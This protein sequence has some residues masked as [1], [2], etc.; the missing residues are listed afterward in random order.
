MT[1]SDVR[2]SAAEARAIAQ[3]AYIYGFPMVDNYRILHAYF[4]NR[5]SPEYKGPWNE[6]R[7]VPRVFSPDDKAIQT[8]NSD[9]PYSFVGL[10]LRA[11]P[12]VL[13]LPPIEQERYFSVQLIDL[14][15]HNFA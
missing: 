2:I 10:D 6:I 14:Y 4:V 12:M 1:R 13:T 8:P 7:H 11:E 9:T 5:Q 15:T 3:Q